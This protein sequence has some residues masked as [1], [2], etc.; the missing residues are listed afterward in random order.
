MLATE[1]NGI[2]QELDKIY[3]RE[4]I[5]LHYKKWEGGIILDVFRMPAENLF[6]QYAS[7][8]KKVRNIT[9]RR[10]RFRLYMMEN[11]QKELIYFSF[12]F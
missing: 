4:T 11:E 9:V 2:K 5:I 8:Q 7:W 6:L 1:S 10:K 12:T 3:V